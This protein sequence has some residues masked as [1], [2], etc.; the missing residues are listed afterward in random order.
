MGISFT[1]L[2]VYMTCHDRTVYHCRQTSKMLDIIMISGISEMK[3]FAA[4]VS[5]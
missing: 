4:L 2:I 3:C 1:N 5:T